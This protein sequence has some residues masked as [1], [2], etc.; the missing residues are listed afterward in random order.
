MLKSGM[1]PILKATYQE[2]NQLKW[3]SLG[4]F[5]NSIVGAYDHLKVSLELSDVFNRRLKPP[6][7][8]PVLSSSKLIHLVSTFALQKRRPGPSN[9]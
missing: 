5:G 3:I 8:G 6:Q 4:V 7:N 9:F 2:D 1:E